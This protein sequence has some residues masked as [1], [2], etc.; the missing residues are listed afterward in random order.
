MATS[1]NVPSQFHFL[2]CGTNGKVAATEESIADNPGGHTTGYTGGRMT[3]IDAQVHIWGA[4]TPSLP[5]P[6]CGRIEQQ[7]RQ[8]KAW[9]E[10]I[11]HPLRTEPNYRPRESRLIPRCRQSTPRLP[12]SARS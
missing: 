12:E 7:A 6:E 4:D 9:P 10:I 3:I 5:W 2:H 1:R 11:A 8:T